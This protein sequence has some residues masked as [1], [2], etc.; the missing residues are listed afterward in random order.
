MTAAKTLVQGVAE[1]AVLDTG[2]QTIVNAVQND[3]QAKGW[4]REAEPGCCAFCALLT[5]RGMTYRSEH[6]A[7]F[8]AH[9]ACRCHATPV[10]TAYE[11]SAQ[12]RDWKALYQSS[13]KGARGMDATIAAYRAAYDAKYLASPAAEPA[14]ELVAV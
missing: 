8:K 13:T 7:D 3:S 9:N 2:R 11:P 12:V 6:T 14:K 4:A 1:T 5:T 10:F